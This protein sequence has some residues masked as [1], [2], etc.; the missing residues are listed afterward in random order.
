[1]IASR[2]L[3]HALSTDS[4]AGFNPAGTKFDE[5]IQE[6]LSHKNVSGMLQLESEFVKNSSECGFRTFLILMGILKNVDYTYRQH[7][8]ESPFGVGYL[9]ANFII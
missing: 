8:Y 7:S 5:K 4:P 9:T 6:L 1:V 3:S 2:D